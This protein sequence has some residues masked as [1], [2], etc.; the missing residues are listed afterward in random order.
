MQSLITLLEN[1][2]RPT[3]VIAVAGLCAVISVV[4]LIFAVLLFVGA[5]PLSY[6]SVLLPGGLEQSGP[7]SFLIYGTLTAVMAG[8]LWARQGWA[9]RLTVLLASLGIAFAVPAISSAVADG[10]LGGIIREGLQ[11]MLRVALV[12]YL[13][14]EPVR[15]WFA[16]RASHF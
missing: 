5:M 11:I 3:G 14:Q 13:S 2:E 9:R 7:E 15:D 1:N 10:R 12:Y 6:G 4:S 8:G 16:T